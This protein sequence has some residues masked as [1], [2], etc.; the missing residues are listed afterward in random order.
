MGHGI[1]D[2]WLV[3]PKQSQWNNPFAN[4]LYSLTNYMAHVEQWNLKRQSTAEF[5]RPRLLHE[6]YHL[7][8]FVPQS[9]PRE[10]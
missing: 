6:L 4:Y 10:S 8:P 9:S 7:R 5:R 2:S 3:T 1:S